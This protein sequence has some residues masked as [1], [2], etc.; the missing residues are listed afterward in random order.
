MGRGRDEQLRASVYLDIPRHKHG[1]DAHGHL[2][3]LLCLCSHSWECEHRQSS[4]YLTGAVRSF[5]LVNDR[6][7]QAHAGVALDTPREE[8]GG[9]A[10]SFLDRLRWLRSQCRGRSL[11]RRSVSPSDVAESL[12]KLEI[13]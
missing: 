9:D 7:D 4:A 2:D 8:E 13:K 1:G 12:P 6:G 11:P 10:S 3:R 5:P